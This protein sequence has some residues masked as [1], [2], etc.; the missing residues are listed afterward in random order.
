MQNFQLTKGLK[1]RKTAGCAAD[2]T[3]S[4][5]V[6]TIEFLSIDITKN[7]DNST[8]FAIKQLLK[9]YFLKLKESVKL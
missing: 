6:W 5:T 8:R 4:K 9:F 1:T 2:D 3:M 7:V